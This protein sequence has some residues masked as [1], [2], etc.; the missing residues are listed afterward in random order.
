MLDNTTIIVVGALVVAALV[1]VLFAV[2]GMRGARSQ[3]LRQRFGPEY[4]RAVSTAGSREAA[5]KMLEERVTRRER[6]EVRDLDEADRERY[7]DSWRSAQSKFVDDPR[8]ALREADEL[9]SGLMRARGYPTEDFEQQV[10]DVSVDHGDAIEAY[11][12]AHEAMLARPHDDR[13]GGELD[14]DELRRAMVDYR[15]VFES[16][17][18]QPVKVAENGGDEAPAVTGRRGEEVS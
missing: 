1:L 4:E 14:A 6:L 2:F 7:A 5:E 8:G 16:L 17:L 3:R 13:D 12:R 11:R 18:G 15:A 9:V 10:S